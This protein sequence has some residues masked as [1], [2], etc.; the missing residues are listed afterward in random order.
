MSRAAAKRKTRAAVL[1]AA[2]ARRAARMAIDNGCA[3]EVTTPG[4][5]VFRFT[6][7][8]DAA[9]APEKHPWDD[10]EP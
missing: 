10:A 9:K 1:R 6:P 5:L 4:G 8:G 2:D 7:L 3:V